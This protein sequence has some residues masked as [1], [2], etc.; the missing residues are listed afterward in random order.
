MDGRDD[1]VKVEVIS[2]FFALVGTC[3]CLTFA[4]ISMGGDRRAVG[5]QQLRSTEISNPWTQGLL[6]QEHQYCWPVRSLSII[7]RK[8]WQ[9]GEKPAD[10]KVVNVTFIFK[11][12]TRYREL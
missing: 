4:H 6:T 1:T 9:A 12:N 2:S 7:Y 3:E 10:Y 11:G 8:S 5:K